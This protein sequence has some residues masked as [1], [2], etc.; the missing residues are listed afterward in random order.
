M[1]GIR[2]RASRP[3]SMRRSS[4]ARLPARGRSRA[5]GQKKSRRAQGP[6]LFEAPVAASLLGHF[7][8]A[9]SGG[10]LYRK[11]SF[12]VDSLGK[13]IFSPLVDITEDPLIVQG[14]AS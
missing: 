3:V 6:V 12:L 4:L 1:T 2:R 11:S 10:S 14:E 5:W 9:V 13:Q 8:S 7:V